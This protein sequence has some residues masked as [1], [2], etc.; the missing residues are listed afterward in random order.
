MPGRRLAARES[1]KHAALALGFALSPGMAGCSNSS[2]AGADSTNNPS[3]GEDGGG[4]PAQT[5]G[6]ATSGGSSSGSGATSGGA[7]GSGASASGSA[8][9]DADASVDASA[10]TGADDGGSLVLDSG[11]LVGVGDA[12]G[13]CPAPAGI[14]TQQTTALQ[15]L[16]QTRAAMG[17]PCATMVPTLNTSATNHCAYYAA[18]LSNAM[19]IVDPHVEVQSCAK[20]VAANFGDRE[21]A[22]GYKCQ[23]S[24]TED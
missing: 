23:P 3:P 10:G 2:S 21:T 18:N 7:S 11:G 14:T 8:G 1:A 15:I 19:C 9:A 4:T 12:G 5:S 16:N 22:A 13:V 17:S 24:L 6:S 20:F